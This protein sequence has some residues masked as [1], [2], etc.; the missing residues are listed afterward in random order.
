MK[1]YPYNMASVGAASLS[2]ALGW[3]RLKEY[4]PPLQTDVLLNWGASD[5]KR[6][7][8]CDFVLNRPES[9]KR[10]LAR[11]LFQPKG[12]LNAKHFRIHVFRD[13][14]FLTQIRVGKVLIDEESDVH[15]D[16]KEVA[17]TIV[18]DLCLDFA[19]IDILW[20]KD[21]NKYYVTRVNTAPEL[22]DLVLEKYVEQFKQ[23]I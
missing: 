5:I 13:D 4:G 10:S 14:A 22:K 11:K 20:D 8:N 2:S 21:N 16:A 3:K 19:A 17:I 18:D 7:V 23:F 6:N 9:V 1:I 15:W 12:V